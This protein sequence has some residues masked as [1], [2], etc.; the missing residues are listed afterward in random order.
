MIDVIAHAKGLFDVLGYAGTGPKIG[1][2]TGRLS[3]PEQLL[4]Q[5][6]ALSGGE[7][8]RSSAG[9]NRLQCGPATE[10]YGVLPAAHAARID[11][12]TTRYFCLI[13]PL[14]E[15]FGGVLTLALQLIGSSLRSDDSP[16]KDTNCIGD[17]LC[18]C[19]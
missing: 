15:Q 18:R 2:E 13:Q 5:S 12:Q 16:Q 3:A 19:R 9:G 7:F 10:S 6:L 8:Q 4:F 11:L 1:G 17:Y 14:A